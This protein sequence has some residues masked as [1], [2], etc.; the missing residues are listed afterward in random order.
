MFQPD[1]DRP[2]DDPQVLKRQAQSVTD[3]TQESLLHLGTVLV[4]F[5]VCLVVIYAVPA[6]ADFRPW[7]PGEPVPFATV[8]QPA[9]V[10]S[11]IGDGSAYRSTASSAEQLTD[12]V[13]EAVAANLGDNGEA[14]EEAVVV[15]VGEEVAIDEAEYAE[16][17]LALA[18]PGH[19]GMAPFYE[20][21]LKTFRGEQ[22]LTRVS[23][24]GDSSIATDL[25]TSTIRR[26]MQRRFGDGGHGFVL[27]AK[28]Y[29]P[30]RHRDLTHRFSESW[31]LKEAV[32]QHDANGM[33]G[34][35][36]VQMVPRA[37]AWAS[38]GTDDDAPVGNAVSSFTLLFQR[39][40]R[41]G[42]LWLTLDD[43]ER[44]ALST[45]GE[46]VEDAMHRVEVPDGEHTFEVKNGGGGRNQLYGMV[47]E[48]DAGVV[49]DS[50]GLVGAR[51]SRM[52]NFDRDHLQRQLAI[53]ESNLI[54]LGFGGNDASDRVTRESYEADFR[55]VIQHVREAGDGRGCLVFGP[56][57]QA[58][59]GDR[60]HIRTMP[61]IPAIVE[62]QRAAAA[63][64][65]CAYFDTFNAM[66]GEGAMRRWH[67]ARPRLAMGDFRHATPA[68]YAA[69][70]NMLYK[71]I[72]KGFAE[73][74]A[75]QP[76][77]SRVRVDGESSPGEVEPPEPTNAPAAPVAPAA[78]PVAAPVA[79]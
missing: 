4:V 73:W 35:G 53:R 32:R 43:G 59:R 26:R 77:T 39:H 76:A 8:F 34:Y 14:P 3:E 57:D 48:R 66:G 22:V 23:H 17:G 19:R 72:L 50:L 69:L 29:L 27:M 64:E 74:L 31:S 21:L 60:G 9:P 47:M 58:K 40:P 65:G 51:A 2:E 63:T 7:I 42:N 45:R 52:R 12:E 33:Y 68:G 56:L 61:T 30:Y 41:G 25:I 44:V 18:D 78:A 49:Y 11:S 67:R 16:L 54:V 36:G 5:A 24:Y 46:S 6:L 71:A 13:G 79:P 55:S 70:G 15:E 20:Q 37:R 62:A 1:Q 38:F 75:E 28:G 10:A